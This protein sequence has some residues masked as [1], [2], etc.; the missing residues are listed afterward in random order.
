M[1]K[2]QNKRLEAFVQRWRESQEQRNNSQQPEVITCQG[3]GEDTELIISEHL[4]TGK[5]REY[6]SADNSHKTSSTSTCENLLIYENKKYCSAMGWTNLC[7]D[8][9]YGF[10]KVMG[11][12]YLECHRR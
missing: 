8:A 11:E 1:I 5:P 9:G 12:Y 6:P 10:K 3:G 2:K 7:K 4:G